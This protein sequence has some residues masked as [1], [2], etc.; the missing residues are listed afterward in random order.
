MRKSLLAI[1]S[2]CL[3]VAGCASTDYGMY[4]A[5][6]QKIAQSNAMADAA[7]YAAIAEIA[8]S[9]DSAAKVAAVMSL[10]M[11][12]GNNNSSQ[13]VQVAAPKSVADTALQWASV[14]LPSLTQVY[15]ISANRQ[16]AITQSNNQAAVATST[17]NTFA[18]MSGNM[19]KSNTDIAGA[20]FNSV[21]TTTANGLTAATNIANSIASAGF[22][23]VTTTAANG[24]TATTNVANSG[25]TGLTTTAANGLTATTNV[26]NSGLTSTTNVA[27]SGLTGVLT[28]GL[29][30]LTA[31]TNISNNGNNSVVSVSNAANASIQSLSSQ[32][33]RI[34]PN[35]TTTTTTTTN[36]TSTIN[37][38][39]NPPTQ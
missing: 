15:G 12:G 13:T 6:Q 39:L 34:Q 8:K 25:L 19:A 28:I 9:G 11:G 32:L 36:N 29:N 33:S 5:T 1:V 26:A 2:T 7:K 30:G 38:G 4:V 14:V 21:T 10:H 16:V 35:V 23:S 27:N 20:G 3:V 17:N 18:A 24:L 31:A 22:N 37:N